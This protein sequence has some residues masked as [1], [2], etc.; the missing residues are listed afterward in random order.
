MKEET[1]ATLRLRAV[2]PADNDAGPDAQTVL[3]YLTRNPDFLLR[4]ETLLAE[5]ELPHRAGTAVSLVE[6][7]VK[8][9]RER[10]IESRQRLTRLLE[11][12]HQND[13]LFDKTRQLIL[14]LL[15]ADSLERLTQTLVLG[16]RREFDIEHVRLL[17]IEDAGTCWPDSAERMRRDDAEA[18]L[19]GMLH[20]ARPVAGPLRPAARELL[21]GSQATEVAS[22]LVVTIAKARPL[23]VLALGSSDVRRFHGE[24]GTLFAEFVGDVLQRLLPH[25]RRED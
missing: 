24:M 13:Q 12:A 25:W 3:E 23:A 11:T 5:I 16:L 17:L 20:Q 22:A 21:F 8:L 2:E 10:N 19:G 9:L 1:V 7:Q 15:E 6:R 4:H 14:M 18:A